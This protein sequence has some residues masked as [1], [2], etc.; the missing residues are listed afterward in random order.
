MTTITQPAE[1]ETVPSKGVGIDYEVGVIG[2]GFAGLVAGLSLLESG[3]TSMI[4]LERASE[5]GGV[6]RDTRYPG[7]A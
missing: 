5:V 1:A 4:I 3:R 6:W 7:C 2:A